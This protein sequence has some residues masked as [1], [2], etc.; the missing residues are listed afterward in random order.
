MSIQR[1]ERAT[2]RKTVLRAATIAVTLLFAIV[3]ATPQPASATVVGPSGT[4]YT[5]QGFCGGPTLGGSVVLYSG[6][7]SMPATFVRVHKYDYSSGQLTSSSWSRGIGIGDAMILPPATASSR[8][9]AL[10]IEYAAKNGFGQYEFVGE[11]VSF[12]SSYWC[13]SP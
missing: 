9:H 5:A 8:W 4:V 3:V 6:L 13:Y 7:S 10:Y 11:W 1:C 12:G 2:A